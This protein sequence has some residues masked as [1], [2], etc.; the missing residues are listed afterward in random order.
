MWSNPIG[1]LWRVAPPPCRSD[2]HPWR[3]RQDLPRRRR[4]SVV[5]V[6]DVVHAGVRAVRHGP[7]VVFPPL[8]SRRQKGQ[9]PTG[10]CPFDADRS[11]PI[12]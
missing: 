12:P 1:R 11:V 3:G 10:A 5:T 9:A 2:P 6:G 4:P 8:R 7:P